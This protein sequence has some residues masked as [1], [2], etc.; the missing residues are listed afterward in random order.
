[1]FFLITKRKQESEAA[2]PEKKL[3]AIGTVAVIKTDHKASRSRSPDPGRRSLSGKADRIT[4]ER[5][6]IFLCRFAE[7]DR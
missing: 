6:Q 2:H 1:M 4:E 3:Y 7:D 5:K